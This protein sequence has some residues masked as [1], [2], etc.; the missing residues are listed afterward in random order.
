MGPSCSASSFRLSKA[1]Q[2]NKGAILR[3]GIYC[4]VR[5]FQLFRTI[6][7]H[8]NHCCYWAEGK[9]IEIN[10]TTRSTSTGICHPK[11]ILFMLT[12]NA[13]LTLKSAIIFALLESTYV[14]LERQFINKH[15]L[16][17]SNLTWGYS[18]KVPEAIFKHRVCFEKH[19]APLD[20]FF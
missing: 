1:W 13:F 2:A 3:R 20:G 19:R 7:I 4:G 16:D 5:L 11:N 10:L 15:N 8:Y 12:I 9:R 6:L 14:Y 18:A 17:A